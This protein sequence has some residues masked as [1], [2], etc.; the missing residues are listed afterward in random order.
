MTLAAGSQYQSIMEPGF[1][2]PALA[3]DF[4]AVPVHCHFSTEPPIAQIPSRSSDP[5]PSAC[6]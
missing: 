3:A 5:Q 4:A 2:L 1:H 6:G